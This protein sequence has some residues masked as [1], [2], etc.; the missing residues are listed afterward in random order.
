M[1]RDMIEILAALGSSVPGWSRL[2]TKMVNPID[3]HL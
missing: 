1:Q 3:G 2:V